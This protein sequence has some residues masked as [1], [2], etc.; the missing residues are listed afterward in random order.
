MDE[1]WIVRTEWTLKEWL[2]KQNDRHPALAGE[3]A[4]AQEAAEMFGSEGDSE[5]FLLDSSIDLCTSE[6]VGGRGR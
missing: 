5:S 1:A 4:Q 2:L 3:G 6:S